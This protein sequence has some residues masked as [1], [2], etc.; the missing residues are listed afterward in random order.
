MFFRRYLIPRLIQY[1]LVI[2][3]GITAV[4][5]HPPLLPNDPVLRTIGEL[6][7]AR[8]ANLEPAQHGQDHRRDD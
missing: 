4:F 2:F 6:R 1:V 7:K 5:H 3:F 8:G